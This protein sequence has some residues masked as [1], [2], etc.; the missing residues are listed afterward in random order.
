MIE[1]DGLQN[2][3]LACD[4]NS[5]FPDKLK[6]QI[7]ILKQELDNERQVRFKETAALTLHIEIIQRSYEELSSS[8]NAQIEELQREVLSL[9]AKRSRLMK[10][11]Y[12][13]TKNIIRKIRSI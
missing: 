9:K 10:R 12:K 4:A 11:I 5:T 13:K 3:Q 7:A 2:L 1:P 8:K 6:V